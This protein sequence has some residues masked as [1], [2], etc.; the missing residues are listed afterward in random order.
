MFFLSGILG[1]IAFFNTA[2]IEQVK[3]L[4]A[5]QSEVNKVVDGINHSTFFLL[6]VCIFFFLALLPLEE[7]Y[8][9]F[10]NSKKSAGIDGI[11]Q[12][13][14]TKDFFQLFSVISF[15]VGFLGFV[16]MFIIYIIDFI[17]LL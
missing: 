3:L 4:G 12:S 16:I 9:S 11:T 6:L 13:L 1:I 8:K 7:I 15:L 10:F 5:P 2:A 14:P 17:P